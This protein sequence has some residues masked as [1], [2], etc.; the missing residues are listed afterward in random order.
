MKKRFMICRITQHGVEPVDRVGSKKVKA[1]VIRSIAWDIIEEHGR[2]GTYTVVE[3]R[4]GD[5]LNVYGSKL[6]A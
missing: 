2:E 3:V 4:M 1:Y 6:R 5:Y